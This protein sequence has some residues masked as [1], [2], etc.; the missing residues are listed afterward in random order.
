MPTAA[1][2]FLRAAHGASLAS[3]IATAAAPHAAAM[4]PRSS[5]VAAVMAF[6]SSRAAACSGLGVIAPLM[7]CPTRGDASM[8]PLCCA[9]FDT[10]NAYKT[11]IDDAKS[12]SDKDVESDEA[13]WALYER[14][15]KAFNMEGDHAEMA[16]QFKIFRY[17]AKYVHH[18]NTYLPPDPEEPAIYIQKR[19]EAELLLR[20][21]GEDVSDFDECHLPIELGPFDD[22]GDP[23]I[24]EHCKRLLEQI[25]ERE[26][27]QERD[28]FSAVEDVTAEKFA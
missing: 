5:C 24:F 20:D 27:I 26:K 19:R 12:L 9:C 14:W 23:F 18:F 10:T 15:C 28:P 8:K 3:H 13:V 6:R 16:R 7:S 22:G 1:T 21:M 17:Y 25:E 11:V 4:V 2:K